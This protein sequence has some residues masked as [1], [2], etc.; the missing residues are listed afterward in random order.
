MRSGH[1]PRVVQVVERAAGAEA[2]LT[3]ALIVQLHRQ[4]DHV[5]TL[6]GE[7]GRGD[8]RIHPARH[9]DNDAHGLPL[10][11]V[12]ADSGCGCASSRRARGSAS[13]TRSISASVLRGRG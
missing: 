8:R 5:V 13:T 1:A 3:L 9:R 6:L 10:I 2:G 11:V 4:T 7:Q 12:R